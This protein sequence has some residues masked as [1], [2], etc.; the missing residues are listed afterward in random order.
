MVLFSQVSTCIC[1]EDL[2]IVRKQNR[3]TLID[4]VSSGDGASRLS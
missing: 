2:S 3:F 1:L 4:E